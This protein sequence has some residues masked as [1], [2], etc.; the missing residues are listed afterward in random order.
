M[1]TD[2]YTNVDVTQQPEKAL[3]LIVQ[4]ACETVASAHSGDPDFT[5]S[6]L[7]DNDTEAPTWANDWSSAVTNAVVTVIDPDSHFRQNNP[8]VS[9][10]SSELAESLMRAGYLLAA[11]NTAAAGT[12]PD[13]DPEGFADR[14]SN[15]VSAALDFMVGSPAVDDSAIMGARVHIALAG[16]DAAADPRHEQARGYA[17]GYMDGIGVA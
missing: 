16:F 15:A 8:A 4:H 1:H 9:M 14:L 5:L 3:G 17:Q 11:T 13:L 6:D 10:D 12:S 2:R 7:R